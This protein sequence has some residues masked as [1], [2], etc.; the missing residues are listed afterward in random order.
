MVYLEGGVVERE[1]IKKNVARFL[2]IAAPFAP[3][4]A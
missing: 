3:E 1:I 2:K 4:M